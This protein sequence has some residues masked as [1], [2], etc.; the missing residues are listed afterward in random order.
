VTGAAAAQAVLMQRRKIMKTF[1]QKVLDSNL[2]LT[3]AANTDADAEKPEDAS[4]IQALKDRE[5]ALAKKRM[6]QLPLVKQAIE[7]IWNDADALTHRFDQ[8][9]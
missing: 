8:Q 9:K 2:R 1:N 7:K 3:G 4:R 5:E 6:E